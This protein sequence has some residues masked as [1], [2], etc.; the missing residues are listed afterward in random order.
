M[1]K[2]TITASSGLD[3]TEVGRMV[4]EAEAHAAEDK[5]KR[6][7]VEQKN[8]AD[9]LVYQME[10]L[11]SENGEKL[12]EEDR[13]PVEEAIA[14]L[15]GAIEK[16][17]SDGIKSGTERLEQASQK[18]ATVL[19]QSTAAPGGDDPGAPG[20]DA[21]GPAEE[22]DVIEAEVVDSGDGKGGN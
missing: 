1:Q 5:E 20:P 8:R 14:D 12:S 7:A 9:Q 21:S 11:L 4:Q 3:E 18:L 15:K 13:K 22:E 16:E 19:Y 10:K 17:D 6:E 2:I